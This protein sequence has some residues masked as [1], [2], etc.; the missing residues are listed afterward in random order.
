MSRDYLTFWL[1][2]CRVEVNPLSDVELPPFSEVEV[3]TLSRNVL[4][5][6][7]VQSLPTRGRAKDAV[8]QK[9]FL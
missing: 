7:R 2:G 6:F 3:S 9:A 4:K 5:Y 8:Y 1:K